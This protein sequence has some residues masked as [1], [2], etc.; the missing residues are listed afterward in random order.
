MNRDVIVGIL[1]ATILG[2]LL[3]YGVSYATFQPTI[4][5]LQSQ[6]STFSN[7]INSLN[8]SISETKTASVIV[9]L[10]GKQEVPQVNTSAWGVAFFSLSK[11]GS[12]LSYTLAVDNIDQVTM[13]HIHLAPAPGGVGGVVVWLYPSVPPAV[14]IPGTSNGAIAS[15]TITSANLV[16]ALAG[17]PFSALLDALK[18]GK[19]Y[20]NVHTDQYPNG[21]IR[22]DI[23]VTSN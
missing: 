13:A 15:G 19:T 5:R 22:G 14:L 20:V 11:N 8:Q 23:I 9:L 2:G 7:M 16:G 17:Q 1:V 4:Q 3:G 12:T 21:E 6:D 10:S 18:S